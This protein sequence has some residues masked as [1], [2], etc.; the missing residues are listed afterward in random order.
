MESIRTETGGIP[1]DRWQGFAGG[2]WQDRID[3]RDFIQANVAPYTG[4]A[5]FLAGPTERATRLPPPATARETIQCLYLAYLAA[6]KEQNGAAMSLGRTSTFLDIYLE[7]DRT[8]SA[9][10]RPN[11]SVTSSA[12]LTGTSL[13]AGST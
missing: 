2:R 1:A 11:R 3:V 8:R 4:D 7:R 6:V 12:S 5:A 10:H 13:A 9:G